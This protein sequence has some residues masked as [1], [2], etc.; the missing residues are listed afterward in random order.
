MRQCQIP[1][2]NLH[3]CA[4]RSILQ[5]P[6][7]P[8]CS[9]G[10]EGSS[11]RFLNQSTSH[12][13]FCPIPWHA[14]LKTQFCRGLFLICASAQ[15]FGIDLANPIK[16]RPDSLRA[17]P[18]STTCENRRLAAKT[19]NQK[20]NFR[21]TWNCLGL[22]AP[23]EAVIC[24]NWPAVDGREPAPTTPEAFGN[25]LVMVMLGWPKFSVFVRL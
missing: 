17:G 13:A 15:P 18:G 14:A 12:T 8:R 24:P 9:S 6:W 1:R 5:A 19:L 22:R 16:K 10:G 3:L 4:D 2:N 23:F 25:H 20:I 11:S 21:A 7:K